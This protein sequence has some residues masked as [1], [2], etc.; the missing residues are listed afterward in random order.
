[1]VNVYGD[2]NNNTLYGDS[3]NTIFSGDSLYGY[4]GNDILY[5]YKY[6]DN[7]YGG[8]NDDTYVFKINYYDSVVGRYTGYGD[9]WKDTINE[10]ANQGSDT[11]KLEGV[12]PDRVRI[13][14]DDKNNLIFEFKDQPDQHV[15][16][17]SIFNSASNTYIITLEKVQ[18]DNGTIWNLSNGLA[19]SG[20]EVILITQGLTTSGQ[21]LNGTS[22]NDAIFGGYYQDSIYGGDGD[23]SIYG[24][25][26]KYNEGYSD[27]IEGGKGNDII[28]STNDSQYVY[29]FG[30]GYDQI[31]TA[32]NGGTY[33]EIKFKN[34]GSGDV[35]MWYDYSDGFDLKFQIGEDKNSGI[36]HHSVYSSNGYNVN[37]DDVVFENGQNIVT[38]DLDDSVI[39][40][41]KA[42][43]DANMIGSINNRDEIIQAN[44]GNDQ[45][46][47][48][49]GSDSIDGGAGS[50]IINY[51]LSTSSI[52]LSLKGD[53]TA[54]GYAANHIISGIE[55]ITG[56]DFDDTLKGDDA[57]NT[58]KGLFGSDILKGEGGSDTLDGG[59]F[60]K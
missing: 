21:V 56:S 19:T 37:I 52:T 42:N 30:D 6:S 29:S 2:D 22:G 48:S 12:T 27:I 7:L 23:D 28:H 16:V 15:Y 17:P 53:L 57:A 43:N 40:T 35:Y 1:M 31:F 54:T 11:L 51:S 60:W 14:Y 41:Y 8:E 49:T 44:G 24:Y 4:G 32:V 26:L 58:L 5:G 10:N 34:I 59:G 33:T 36:H 55:N 18:F 3:N 47:A 46:F 45:I 50:D 13:L 25:G 20:A 9:G 39:D 38:W